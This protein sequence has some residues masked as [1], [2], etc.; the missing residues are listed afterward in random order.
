[1]ERLGVVSEASLN[2]VV[3][4]VED[5]VLKWDHVV[6]RYAAGRGEEEKEVL[7]L[8]LDVWVE[9]ENRKFAKALVLG[10]L[11]EEVLN[12]ARLPKVDSSV[13]RAPKERLEEI[14]SRE[15]GI[16]IGKL[17][18]DDV[19]VYVEPFSD[20][21]VIY[22]KVEQKVVIVKNIVEEL[23]RKMPVVYLDIAGDFRD[24]WAEVD[25]SQYLK[26]LRGKKLEFPDGVSLFR[27]SELDS[28]MA[29]YIVRKI[30]DEAENA[31]RNVAVILDIG[32]RFDHSRLA[33]FHE[34]GE[35][36]E[37]A[38]KAARFN[39]NFTLIATFKPE[40]RWYS[41]F[42]YRFR[43]FLMTESDPLCRLPVRESDLLRELPNLNPN[44][45]LVLGEFLSI[46]A[47]VEFD[48]AF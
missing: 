34:W 27:I 46:P 10:Y 8:V 39:P 5:E 15:N 36:V 16:R 1:M 23:V 2:E 24:R 6:L 45:A 3:F 42:S 19:M 32:D 18:S 35:V 17:V 47:V 30:L 21:A 33:R 25:D 4:A 14:F 13:F 38:L 29:P 7:C 22:R 9:K 48:G 12:P 28:R 20:L 43:N 40:T 26:L 31:G 11:N 41:R 44:E 37:Y